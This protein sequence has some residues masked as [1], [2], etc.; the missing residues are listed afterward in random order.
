MASRRRTIIGSPLT[1]S[2]LRELGVL[3]ELPTAPNGFAPDGGWSHT[4]RVWACHGYRETGNRNVG[5]LRIEREPDGSL[6]TFTLKVDQQIVQV[7]GVLNTIRA[8][9]ACLNDQL[10]SPIR[11][12]LSSRFVGPEGKPR[13]KLDVEERVRINGDT[14]EVTTNGRTFKRKGSSRLTAD[15]C[16]FEAVQRLPFEKESH[17]TFDVLEGLSLL[18]TGHRLSYRGTVELPPED[19]IMLHGF[20]RLGHGALPYEYWLDERRRLVMVVTLS[21]VYVLGKKA[22]QETALQLEPQRRSFQRQKRARERGLT[23]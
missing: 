19:S 6:E 1:P 20:H 9:I 15:W 23:R 21:R 4:Y 10:G 11:W 22:E 2:L 16:L 13:P 8:E 3:G 17:L 12:H 14:L 5:F 18:R 7:E